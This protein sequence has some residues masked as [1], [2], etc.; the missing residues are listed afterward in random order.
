M[1]LQRENWKGTCRELCLL[2]GG[3]WQPS[4][5]V[6]RSTVGPRGSQEQLVVDLAYSYHL[7]VV[8]GEKKPSAFAGSELGPLTTGAFMG[9][10]DATCDVHVGS[11]DL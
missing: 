3:I 11:V 2:Q 10:V 7:M 5:T 6:C 4:V 8:P 9:H 1:T